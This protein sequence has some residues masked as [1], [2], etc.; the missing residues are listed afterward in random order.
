MLSITEAE[1]YGGSKQP[2][3]PS[4]ANAVELMMIDRSSSFL[5]MS[6][7]GEYPNISA[8]RRLI[9]VQDPELSTAMSPSPVDWRMSS[10]F[11]VS[12]ARS[13]S[14]RCRSVKSRITP[15][16]FTREPDSSSGRITP[17]R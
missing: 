6:S 1:P 4:E 15:E 8:P 10:R 2:G 7:A 5:P 11:L 3:L 12:A 9:M 13:S 16:N 14:A 17:S